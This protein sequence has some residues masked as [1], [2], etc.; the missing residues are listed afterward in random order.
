MENS[1]PVTEK[2]R[3][4]K[5]NE[6]DKDLALLNCNPH[7]IEWEE[8]CDGSWQSRSRNILKS[9]KRKGVRYV[10]TPGVVGSPSKWPLSE[11]P[12]DLGPYTYLVENYKN[13]KVEMATPSG[14]Y[15]EDIYI[16]NHT[17]VWGSWWKDHQW[18]YKCCQQVT[19]N[20]YCT[21]T[22]GAE[23]VESTTDLIEAD[24][25]SHQKQRRPVRFVDFKA[26]IARRRAVVAREAGLPPAEV[27]G[28]GKEINPCFPQCPS[29]A[30]W[31]QSSEV[32]V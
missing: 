20:S 13:D 25:A 11:P 16:G 8:E 18:G 2:M 10:A 23:V 21:R 28:C 7:I 32:H 4:L 26:F 22:A 27:V 6:T 31:C 5:L 30:A 19:R 17:T 29:S 24:A 12:R 15:K 9:Y 3:E 14:K 1:S